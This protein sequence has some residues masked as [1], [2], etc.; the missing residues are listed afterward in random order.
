[1]MIDRLKQKIKDDVV[2][3]NRGKL[4]ITDF[5]TADLEI[6]EY[7]DKQKPELRQ[8]RLV[9]TLRTGVISLNS[10]QIGERVDYVPNLN[11][12]AFSDYNS[13]LPEKIRI[14]HSVNLQQLR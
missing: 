2:V 3:I 7:F 5:Q 12:F 10:A 1:M 14:I 6:V 9:S 8:D 4:I 11:R 13:K